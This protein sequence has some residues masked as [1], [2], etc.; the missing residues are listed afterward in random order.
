M[1]PDQREGAKTSVLEQERSTKSLEIFPGDWEGAC[2]DSYETEEQALCPQV[3]GRQTPKTLLGGMG[4]FFIPHGF[5]CKNSSTLPDLTKFFKAT[6]CVRC[7]SKK[8]CLLSK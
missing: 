2:E 7:G 4:L 5:V 6:D 1:Q 8:T 3:R